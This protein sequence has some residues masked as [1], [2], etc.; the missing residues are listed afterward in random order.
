MY[1]SVQIYEAAHKSVKL[2]I[3]RNLTNERENCDQVFFRLLLKEGFNDRENGKPVSWVSTCTC[4]HSCMPADFGLIWLNV[5]ERNTPMR[6]R[7]DS[8]VYMH[9]WM[10]KYTCIHTCRHLQRCK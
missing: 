7:A 9:A 10:S 1:V 6:A 3:K 8:M 5:Y 4:S 2:V